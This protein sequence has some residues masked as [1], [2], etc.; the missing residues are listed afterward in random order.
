MRLSPRDRRRVQE[1]SKFLSSVEAAARTPPLATVTRELRTLLNF[2]FSLSYGVEREARGLAVDFAH[3]AG[4]RSEQRMSGHVA[5]I[6][7][8]SG[9]WGLYDPLHPDPKQRNRVH[10][11]PP[12]KRLLT[13]AHARRKETVL[14]LGVSPESVDASIEHLE[15][16]SAGLFRTV[17]LL[18]LTQ[19]RVLV[20]E[21]PRLLA[22]VGGFVEGAATP[23]D[24]AVLRALVPALRDRLVLEQGLAAAPGLATVALSA[25][26]E[27]I[28]GAAFIVSSNGAVRHANA[29]GI[30]RQARDTKALSALLGASVRSGGRPPGVE[31]SELRAPGSPVHF[32]VV[33]KDAVD[34]LT[35]R[36]HQ[37]G[38][39]WGLTRR[40]QEV[41]LLLARG[42]SNKGIAAA[43]G[44]APH[45]VA[46]HVS[47]I[48][49]KADVGNRSSLVAELLAT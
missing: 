41:L 4:H 6:G 47:A 34:Q 28:P 11:T 31:I 35:A 26:L 9:R 30:A 33:L 13:L 40:Q 38:A 23:R 22:W 21:G 25:A 3:A 12:L 18:D 15:E 29:A 5:A 14:G 10:V 44:C 43:L 19:M 16:L 39:R 45:T 8:R 36:A 32:L 48:L 17:G 7:G 37:A 24:R 2:E 46:L 27:H 1:L 20:C 42:E 49:E